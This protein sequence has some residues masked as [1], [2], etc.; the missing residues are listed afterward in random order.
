[1]SQPRHA[2][3]FWLLS[4]AFSAGKKRGPLLVEWLPARPPRVLVYD[5]ECVVRIVSALGNP[6]DTYVVLQNAGVIHG[7]LP[8]CRLTRCGRME[9]HDADHTRNALAG[10]WNRPSAGSRSI[11]AGLSLQDVCV[12]VQF[13]SIS[14]MNLVCTRSVTTT[15]V[16]PCLYPRGREAG[17]RLSCASFTPSAETPEWYCSLIML[18]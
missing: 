5:C 18:S 14:G 15:P 2:H 1:M 4:L 6:P 9:H 12:R 10:A 8:N 3:W 11:S 16:L 7:G 17:G 13:A